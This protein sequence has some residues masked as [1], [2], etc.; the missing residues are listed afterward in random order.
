MILFVLLIL[1]KNEIMRKVLKLFLFTGLFMMFFASCADQ[2]YVTEQYYEEYYNV[3]VFSQEYE[4]G[5]KQHPWLYHE[6]DDLFYCEVSI[7][8]LTPEI[9]DDG[10]IAGYFVYYVGEEK[11]DTPLPYSNFFI[12]NGYQWSYQYTCEFSPYK[13]TFI[14]RDS[15]YAVDSPPACTFVVKMIR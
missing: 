7:E 3:W 11:V 8:E 5:T 12:D 10:L 15:D 9:Y 14:F 4:V 1:T 6:V 2:Y 13:V